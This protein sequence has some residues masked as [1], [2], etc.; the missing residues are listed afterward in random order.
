MLQSS[1]ILNSDILKA[2]DRCMSKTKD[3]FAPGYQGLYN[4]YL[5]RFLDILLSSCAL[6]VLWPLFPICAAAIAIDDGF[7]VLYRADRTGL[8]GESFQICKFRTMVRNA[9]KIGGGTT[10]LRDPR[11]TR[12]GHILRSTKL[13][14]LPQ[15]WQVF[16]GRMSLVGPR[17]ELRKYTS[18]Y[19]GEELDILRVK[20]GITDFSSIEFI[21]L[22]QIV[23]SEHADETYETIVLHRKNQLRIRYA[24]QVSF[25]TD[26]LILCRTASAVVHKGF[27]FL[28]TLPRKE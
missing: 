20:P 11:I 6:L 4:R 9:D 22:D 28:K 3:L 15:L 7:P 23:G 26:L 21:D 1:C 12:I 18:A 10:A 16:T 14:E 19:Q 24:H 13:D 2:G 27:R 25:S 5:K 8:R 17:P